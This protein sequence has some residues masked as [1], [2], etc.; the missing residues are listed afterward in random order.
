MNYIPYLSLQEL[1]DRF[2]DADKKSF[3]DFAKAGQFIGGSLVEDFEKAFANYCGVNHVIGTG[4]GLDALTVILL[5]EIELGNLPIKARI[6]LPAHTYI[7]TF[8]SI[9]NAGLIPVPVDVEELNL[10]VNAIKK[11]KE[12][13]DAIVCV[14]LYGKLVE[15]EVYDYAQSNNFNIYTDTAQSHGAVNSY[16]AISGSFARASAFSFYPTKNLGALGDA[17]AIS[18]N[19]LELSDMCRSIANY[20]RLTRFTN[21]VKGINSRL[22]TLQACF[23]SNRLPFLNADNETRISIATFYYDHLKN[24]KVQLMG[25]DFLSENAMHVFPVFVEN[26]DDFMEYMERNGVE[27]SCHYK[28]P[29]HQQNAFKE[30]NH[31][32]FPVTEKLHST[33]VSLPCH[34]LLSREDIKYIIEIINNY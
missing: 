14:D 2:Y 26:R 11:C 19:D 8:L 28:T 13:Y 30:L 1:Q 18:T 25:R 7:A 29:P 5:S 17:G 34:P 31:L 24:P 9:H 33:E 20:G 16:G 27:T 4:N 32:S 15:N 21:P 10:T 6:L 12:P 3:L 22:D 23:L